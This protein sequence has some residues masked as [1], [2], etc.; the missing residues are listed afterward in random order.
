MPVIFF[1]RVVDDFIITGYYFKPKLKE[2]RQQIFC[3]EYIYLIYY[4]YN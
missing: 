4:K 1:E 2:K 3:G